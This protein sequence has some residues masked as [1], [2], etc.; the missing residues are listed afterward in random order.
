MTNQLTLSSIPLVLDEEEMP[1]VLGFA[2]DERPWLE[3]AGA[4]I[5]RSTNHCSI[6]YPLDAGWLRARVTVGSDGNC[7]VAANVG[8]ILNEWWPMLQQAAGDSVARPLLSAGGSGTTVTFRDEEHLVPV[9]ILPPGDEVGS[10][11]A[12]VA[13]AGGLTDENLLFARIVVLA[14][15][16]AALLTLVEYRSL[17]DPVPDIEVGIDGGTIPL[18]AMLDLAALAA[19]AIAWERLPA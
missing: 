6:D 14:V 9:S 17:V 18:D 19:P 1:F 2:H 10:T 8:P 11:F 5:R 15:I 13:T 7:Y 3:F 16:K 4:E 12:I